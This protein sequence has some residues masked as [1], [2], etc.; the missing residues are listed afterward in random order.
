MAL[1][2]KTPAKL[3]Q[4]RLQ[5]IFEEELILNSSEVNQVDAQQIE[6][7]TPTDLKAMGLAKLPTLLLVIG[8]QVKLIINPPIQNLLTNFVSKYT[9]T[10]ICPTPSEIERIKIQRD[11]I[12]NQLNKVSRTLNII[13]LTLTGVSTFLNLLEASISALNVSKIAAKIAA[14]INPVLAPL[15][16]TTLNTL[17]QAKTKILIDEEGNSRLSKIKAI[18]S[19]ASLVTS[20]VSSYILTAVEGLKAIDSMLK[21]CN[22]NIILEP[23]SSETQAIADVQIQVNQTQNGSTYQGF[24]IEIEEVPFTPTVTRRRAIGKNKDGITLIQTELS[25]TT[26]DQTLINE[27]KF[28][29]DKDNLKAY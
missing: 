26:D 22:P 17:D 21:T 15:L 8:N 27:L 20:V 9:Q 3:E 23:I 25:F 18:I 14:A 12:V 5:Q 24:I 1:P 4:E 11:N 29:I 13:S 19:G 10:Q 28:I 7:A 2:I 16:P 6:N